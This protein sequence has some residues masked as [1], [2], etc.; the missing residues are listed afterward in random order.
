MPKFSAWRNRDPPFHPPTSSDCANAGRGCEGNGPSSRSIPPCSAR[1]P[2]APHRE[3]AERRE[4]QP[5]RIQHR[6]SLFLD[7]PGPASPNAMERFEQRA[8]RIREVTADVLLP[9][10]E[11][12][13]HK[14]MEPWGAPA[15]H[16]CEGKR[17]R[18][19]RPL[20]RLNIEAAG[21]GGQHVDLVYRGRR[22]DSNDVRRAAAGLPKRG[23]ETVLRRVLGRTRP[24]T[25]GRAPP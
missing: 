7:P 23:A 20:P 3:V 6:R 19:A 8:F 25:H 21:V 10:A 22:Q 4:A 1:C 11:L 15:P 17:P 12:P 16:P 13:A 9:H 5:D 14:T 2:W 24:R 18:S